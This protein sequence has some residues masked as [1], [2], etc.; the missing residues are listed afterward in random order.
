MKNNYN[1]TI[2]DNRKSFCLDEISRSRLKNFE[3]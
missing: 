1:E 3:N 2:K